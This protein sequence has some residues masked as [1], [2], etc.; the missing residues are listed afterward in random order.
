MRGQ[1][2]GRLSVITQVKVFS[3]DIFHF[4]C[5]QGFHGLEAGNEALAIGES[6]DTCPGSKSMTG[7][8]TVHIGTW[9]SL[10]APSASVRPAEEA[11]R[12]YGGRAVGLTHS[13]GVAGV[14]PG[15]SQCSLEGVGGKT[16]G[17]Q[18]ASAIH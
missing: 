7:D 12:T 14:M 10:A 16:Q 9:E 4:A 18:E 1:R 11:R 13:R 17:L 3:P 2:F 6:V 5:G 8:R 15:A